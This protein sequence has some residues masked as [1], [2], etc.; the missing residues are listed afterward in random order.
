MLNPVVLQI[1]PIFNMSPATTAFAPG[2]KS[3]SIKPVVS[4]DTPYV[5]IRIN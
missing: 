5:A 3:V 4:V 1:H 2:I